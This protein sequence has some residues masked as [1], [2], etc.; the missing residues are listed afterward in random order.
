MRG[1]SRRF[2][3]NYSRYAD[4]LVFSGDEL[5]SP[6]GLESAVAEIASSEGFTLN[7]Q[8]TRFMTASRRQFVAGAVVNTGVN[9]PRDEADR[10]KA[11]LHN[12]VNRG[13]ASQARGIENFRA[14]LEGRV[15]WVEHLSPHRGA[16]LRAMLDRLR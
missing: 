12:C 9:V 10:L 11:T 8:K 15:G 6:R 7:R 1:L 14:H 5:F 3:A 16:K 13:V 4:D 2:G